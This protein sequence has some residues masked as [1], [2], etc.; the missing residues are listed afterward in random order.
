MSSPVGWC[1]IVKAAT[2]DESSYASL[3]EKMFYNW[4]CGHW[5]QFPCK[6]ETKCQATKEQI[7]A[8]NVRM[9]ADWEQ[10]KLKKNS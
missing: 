5:S 1:E 6:H 10:S 7:D 8:L 9:K 3:K 4:Q 2:G